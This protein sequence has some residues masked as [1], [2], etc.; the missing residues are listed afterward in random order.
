MAYPFAYEVWTDLDR[1][2]PPHQ[3]SVPANMWRWFCREP[4]AYAEL[5]FR[6]LLLFCH[7]SVVP[8]N[9]AYVNADG[10]TVRSHVLAL[11]VL[12]NFLV[13]G[14]LGIAGVGLCLWRR[15]RA[16]PLFAVAL[17]TVYAL[18]I[19]LF[20]ILARF[21]LPAVPLFAGF[22]G[23]YLVGLFDVVRRHRAGVARPRELVK[24]LALLGG[25]LI[26][27]GVGFDAYRHGWEARVLAKVRPNGVVVEFPGGIA[28]QDSGPMPFGGWA[29]IGL[30][31][32]TRVSKTLVLSQPLAPG[33]VVV[34]RLPVAGPRGASG[35]IDVRGERTV[36][37]PFHLPRGGIEWGEFELPPE[38][39]STTAETITVVLEP[40]A[41]QQ[42]D[43]SL[44]VDRQRQYGRTE[45]NGAITAGE[46]VFE[47]RII[48]P[49][50][51]P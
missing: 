25:A 45:V 29:P 13:I 6:M 40:A 50:S 2:E 33:S 43:C 14:S 7:H 16:R 19:V 17:L 36:T 30:A 4:L 51:A 37:V 32:V 1:A 35:A 42:S 21:R 49:P 48:A 47:L 22:A 39:V 15:R 27:V 12:C 3:V 28:I 10:V 18:S 5:K 20:Y 11:P 24:T 8:N 46:L 31:N 26:V 41:G 23:W 44:I 34:A 9:V 38:S